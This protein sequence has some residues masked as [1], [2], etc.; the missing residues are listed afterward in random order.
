MASLR[1]FQPGGLRARLLFLVFAALVPALFLIIQIALSHLRHDEGEA[2]ATALRMARIVATDQEKTLESTL[3]LLTEL[4]RIPGVTA[5]DAK[6][7]DRFLTNLLSVSP[8]YENLA[9]ADSGGRILRSAHPLT[10]AVSVADRGWFRR[11]LQSVRFEIGGY[12]NSP[13]T[14]HRAVAVCV[15]SLDANGKIRAVFCAWIDLEWMNHA[16]LAADLPTR[17]AAME[18]DQDGMILARAPDPKIWIGQSATQSV[19]YQRV[20]S[21]DSEGSIRAA[22]LDRSVRL[23]AYTPVHAGGRTAAYLAIGIPD[24]VAF[25]N[26]RRT[27]AQSVLLLAVT[28]LLIA[29]F[30]WAIGDALVVRRVKSLIQQTNRVASGDLSARTGR[31][32]SDDELGRLE[33]AFDEMAAALEERRNQAQDAEE[34]LHLSELRYRRL[35]EATP[36]PSCVYDVESLAIL[37]VNDSATAAYGYSREEFLQMTILDLF[38]RDAIPSIHAALKVAA[39]TVQMSGEYQ[40]VRKD[41]SLLDVESV[42]HGIEFAGK[43]VRLVIAMDVTEKN[44][45][46]RELVESIQRLRN[47]A[48]RLQTAREDE[49]TR[50]AREVHDE[51]GQALTGLKLDLS[52]VRSR[53]Q[54]QDALASCGISERLEDMSHLID[55]AVHTVRRIATELRPPILDTLGLVPALEWQANDF[56]LRT[57]I[58]CSFKSSLDEL[59]VGSECST[60][61][62]RVF[63]EA[64]TNVARHAKAN[65]VNASLDRVDGHIHLVVADDGVGITE[66]RMANRTSFGISGMRERAD[67]F[68]GRVDL[69]GGA[70]TG[71]VV[72][73]RLPVESGQVPPVA[74]DALEP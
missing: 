4:S 9:I 30:S 6:A 66:E 16:L 51:L 18:T 57:G 54:A 15:P 60:A 43:T 38:P 7:T 13:I 11:S 24:Q 33:R 59:R 47:L 52:S 2:R 29:G 44:R 35:F 25:A 10:K 40:Q 27:L 46:Q 45:I 63:Q 26:A 62:F 8:A 31:P 70:G 53:V 32:T 5:G 69:E 17:S 39:T 41:G 61:I 64:L 65:S 14:G 22:S 23:W 58:V 68:G 3:T 55:G 19:V 73:L 50:V 67:V 71:T 49:R 42:S 34:S 56:Q 37:N 12:E 28:T 20:R 48:Q 36:L 1:R 21:A 72:T 74:S